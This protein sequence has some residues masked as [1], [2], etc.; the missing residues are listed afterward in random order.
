MTSLEDEARAFLNANPQV[1]YLDAFIIDL[2]GR[3][4]G[5]RYPLDQIEKLFKNGSQ[6]CASTSLLDVNG[7]SSDPLGYGFSDGDPDADS[8]P[9]PG[10]LCAAPWGEGKGAQCLMTLKDNGTDTPVWFEPR[11]VL[12]K[13]V[14]QFAELKLRP[15][16]AIELEFYLLD[17]QRD[18]DGKSQPPVNPRGGRRSWSGNVF[19]FDELE[20]YAGFLTK[21]SEIC[22][23]QN[24]PASTAISEYG[25]GQ[26]EINLEHVDDP[27]DAADHAALLR[28]AVMMAA[29]NTGFDATFLSKPYPDLA[30]SGMHIHLSIMDETGANIFDAARADGEQKLKNVGAGF[31]AVMPEAMGIFVPN[32]NAFR[33]FEPNQFT[34]VTKDWGDNNRSMA[35]RMLASDGKNKRIEHR[36]SGAEANP[37]LALAAV[38]AGAYHGLA[39]GLEPTEIASGNA[40][41]SVDEDLPLRPW[42]ALDKLEQTDV[43][44]AYMGDEFLRA[45]AAVKRAELED[46]LSEIM[47]REIEWYL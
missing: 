1:E 28:R 8:F 33:R 36:V 22:Q 27:L 18:E 46:F 6:L 10:T 42:T 3:A 15:V 17:P 45:Y 16:V 29:R 5:K 30:G 23:V 38:L 32:L 7:N 31:Q 25:A 11:I 37:Y 47:P 19:S 24:I 13:V 9:V 39:N 21:I 34:P 2:C 40:G 12:Q 35:F 43:L 14:T 26:F 41:A 4:A 20:D 44:K